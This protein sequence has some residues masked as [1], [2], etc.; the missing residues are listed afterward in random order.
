[1]AR[2]IHL[3]GAPGTGKSSLARR[4]LD[5]HPLTLQIEIDALRTSLGC[6]EP[7]PESRLIAREFGDR[8]RGRAAQKRQRRHRAAVPRTN[9]VRRHLGSGCMRP[10]R[11]LPEVHLQTPTSVASKRFRTRRNHLR[12]VRDRHP[13]ADIADEAIEQALDEAVALLTDLAVIR[14]R[15]SASTLAVHSRRC[16]QTCSPPSERVSGEPPGRSRADG[17]GMLRR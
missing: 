6:W 12:H 11:R 13:E 14:G 7:V 9:R 1:M 3:N 16:T 17:R 5:D 2:L 8:P 10:W 15:S 4:Y